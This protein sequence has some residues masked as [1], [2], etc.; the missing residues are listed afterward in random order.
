MT[1]L[2]AELNPECPDGLI[3][4]LRTLSWTE[5]AFIAAIV[6][7]ALYVSFFFPLPLK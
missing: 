2:N 7:G 5:L 4:E 6:A 1:K 3:H